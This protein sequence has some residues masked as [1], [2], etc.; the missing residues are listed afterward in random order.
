MKTCKRLFR[1]D[2][3]QVSLLKFLLEAYDGL[4]SLSTLDPKQGI[5]VFRIPPQRLAEFDTVLQGFQK[6]IFMEAFP[7]SSDP[8]ADCL[9][10]TGK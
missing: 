10:E 3:H 8:S 5:V 1:V 2:S 6:E 4:A 9:S 7:L